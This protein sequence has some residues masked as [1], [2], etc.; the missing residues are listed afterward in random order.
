L[1]RFGEW[2]VIPFYTRV[3]MAGLLV[4][5]ALFEGLGVLFGALGEPSLMILA[6]ILMVL[7]LVAVVLARRRLL[8]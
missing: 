8:S 5:A 2:K 7:T 1:R 4:Y 3:S 6:S